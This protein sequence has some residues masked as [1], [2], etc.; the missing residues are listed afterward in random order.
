MKKMIKLNLV[1]FYEKTILRNQRK[2]M[3]MQ[4]LRCNIC[5]RIFRAGSRFHRFCRSCKQEDDIFRFSEW[6]PESVL[7]K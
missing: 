6:L 5:S 4:R 1:P 7:I 3:G 2:Q